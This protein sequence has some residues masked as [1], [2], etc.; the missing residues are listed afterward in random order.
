MVGIVLAS[1]GSLSE[2][3]KE[4]GQMI[5]GAQDD[6]SAVVLT[7]DIGPED[8]HTKLL[9]AATSFSDPEHVLFLVDLWGGTPFNQVSRILEEE[10]HDDWVA[11]T[12]LNLPML[13]AA[14]GARMDKQTASEVARE[15]YAEAIGGIKAKP[16]SLVPAPA[17][18]AP[19]P[20]AAPVG[21]IPEGT[22][23]GDGHIKIVLCRI[24][25]RLL[26]G[27]V[28]TTWTKMTG[29]DRI[30]VCSD[31]V[32]RDELRKSMI[33]QAAPPGVKAHVVPVSKIIEVSKDP[34]FGATKA[35]LLF[36]T[37]QDLLRAIEGGVDVKKVNLGSMAHSAGKVVVSNAVAM[38]EDDVKTLEAIKAKGV[39]FDVRKVPAD[40]PEN[41]DAMLKKAKNE[42]ASK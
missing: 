22:V 33:E 28:A 42:L 16:E 15:V 36:E 18:G 39:E 2:G 40:A 38:G 4:S 10:G 14:Y 24:D 7:P 32:A 3:I 19:A 12:G 37:P 27:Q 9:D 13:V 31:A 6:V 25:T 5:F 23:L 17:T 34:R 21:T 11:L 20:A 41:F 8:L 29:P 35:M 30:I 26:H 1:H